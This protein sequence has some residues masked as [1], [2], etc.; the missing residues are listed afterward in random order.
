MLLFNLIFAELANRLLT[1][2]KKQNFFAGLH[3]NVCEIMVL[4]ILISCLFHLY[5]GER[6]KREALNLMVASIAQM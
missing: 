5:M 3:Q 4:Y 6:K 2:R 1:F